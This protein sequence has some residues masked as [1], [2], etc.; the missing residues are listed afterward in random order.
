[1]EIYR[2]ILGNLKSRAII[3]AMEF[4]NFVDVSNPIPDAIVS[5]I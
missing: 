3:N 4:D 2:H 5:R 1:M